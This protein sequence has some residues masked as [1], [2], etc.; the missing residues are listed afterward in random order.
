MHHRR[1]ILAALG[2]AMTLGLGR[3][4]LAHHGWRWTQDGNFELTGIIRAVR[5]GNPHGLLEVDADGEGWTVE[6]GQPWRNER[7]GL[8]D[9]MLVPGVEITASGH[10]AANPDEKRMKAERVTI[11]GQ[12]YELYPDRD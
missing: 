11:D 4:A 8:K 6:V 7:A 2:A 1:T 5:L 10:R 12:L 3:S 9:D